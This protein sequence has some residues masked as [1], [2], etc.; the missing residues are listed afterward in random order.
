MCLIYAS[1]VSS[2]DVDVITQ[3]F[4][5]IRLSRVYITIHDNHNNLPLLIIIHLT[6]FTSTFVP[7][8]LTFYYNWKLI[9]TL[10]V[11]FY[12]L[13]LHLCN[14]IIYHVYY[15]VIIDN[16]SFIFVIVENYQLSFII[17]IILQAAMEIPQFPHVECFR[18]SKI[19]S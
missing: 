14:I 4:R 19:H 2:R 1:K 15:I 6:S 3:N 16:Y 13:H 7:M 12:A 8:F 18:K 11:P 5:A 10:C 9:F 17:L